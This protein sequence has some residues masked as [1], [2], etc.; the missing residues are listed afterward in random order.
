LALVTSVSKPVGGGPK[1]VVL[2][3]QFVLARKFERMQD[4]SRQ[5]GVDVVYVRVDA[6]SAA[7]IGRALDGADFILL[8]IPFVSLFVVDDMGGCCCCWL[9]T[10]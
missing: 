5:Q 6:A 4:I 10:Q 9:M 3:T 2:S 8:D 1:I 7:D